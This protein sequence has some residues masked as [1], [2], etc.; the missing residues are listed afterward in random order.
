MNFLQTLAN[1]RAFYLIPSFG[2]IVFFL[3][4][5]VAAFQYPGGTSLN[6]SH[7]GFCWIEN[8]WCDLI[9]EEAN[10]GAI[11]TAQNTAVIGMIILCISLA[12]IF[13][14]SPLLFSRKHK[15]QTIIQISGIAALL[16]AML[17]MTGYHDEVITISGILGAITLFFAFIELKKDKQHLIFWIG[18]FC[19]IV[20]AINYYL[21]YAQ[22]LLHILPF[23]QKLA[24]L[25][26]LSWLGFVNYKIYEQKA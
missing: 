12:G 1:R 9:A 20:G 25:F 2:I 26:F 24:F 21:Y 18:I 17:I 7:E 23:I 6:P 10:N 22:Q 19:L 13:Y 4:Y 5:M 16:I 8:Y 14:L 3:L 11:N 15:N